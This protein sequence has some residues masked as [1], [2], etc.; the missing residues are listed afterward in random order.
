MRKHFFIFSLSLSVH[1]YL[2]SSCTVPHVR[3]QTPG[4]QEKTEHGANQ[5]PVPRGWINVA[6][7]HVRHSA[8]S[9]G[10][11]HSSWGPLRSHVCSRAAQC[12]QRTCRAKL[13]R[14]AVED[15]QLVID[16]CIL[17]IIFWKWSFTDMIWCWNIMIYPL[18]GYPCYETRL[19]MFPPLPLRRLRPCACGLDARPG[20]RFS[21]RWTGIQLR[22]YRP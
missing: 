15:D 17:Y 22:P 12:P 4:L 19:L 16:G 2:R 13:P 3:G 8:W 11:H 5:L 9:P 14:W 6:R 20:H 21:A 7:R 10:L 18:F 1:S